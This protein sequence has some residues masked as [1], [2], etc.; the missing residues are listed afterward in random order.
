M[1]S[2]TRHTEPFD[3]RS[4][5]YRNGV[6][7]HK[8]R[9][10]KKSRCDA[11]KISASQQPFFVLYIEQGNY[12]VYEK[13][14]DEENADLLYAGPEEGYRLVIAGNTPD[15]RKTPPGDTEAVKGEAFVNGAM[16]LS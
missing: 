10:A 2:Q 3:V 1:I 9:K 11:K 8:W 5:R 15:F 14:G 4:G 12:E 6:G 13:G 16:T 7:H